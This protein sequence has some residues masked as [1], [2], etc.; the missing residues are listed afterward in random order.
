ML[1]IT[2]LFASL[3][4][5]QYLALISLNG[6]FALALLQVSYFLLSL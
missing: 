4:L 2:N 6:N 1:R 3:R 5:L